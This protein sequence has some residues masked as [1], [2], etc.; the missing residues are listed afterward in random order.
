MWLE[1][2]VGRSMSGVLLD[3]DDEPMAQVRPSHS[4]HRG[5]WEGLGVEAVEWSAVD[6]DGEFWWRLYSARR[7]LRSGLVLSL[8]ASDGE[9]QQAEVDPLWTVGTLGREGMASPFDAEP[10]EDG[11]DRRTIFFHG[12][13]R[14]VL[15]ED[16]AGQLWG[17]VERMAR[18]GGR[19]ALRRW[20]GRL[21]GELEPESKPGGVVYALMPHDDV[22]DW[23][24]EA[25]L[26]ALGLVLARLTL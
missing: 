15:I 14:R 9:A 25:A 12:D 11:P 21:L 26:M 19:V 7:G 2:S 8:V 13:T 18:A 5:F 10:D 20:D 1:L 4:H 3:E 17:S 24:E 23:L 22:E 6:D 16:D